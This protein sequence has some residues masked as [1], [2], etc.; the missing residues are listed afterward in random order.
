[1][2]NMCQTCQKQHLWTHTFIF[3]ENCFFIYFLSYS[4]KI[5]RSINSST[6]P[7]VPVLGLW[8]GMVH[9]KTKNT[10]SNEACQIIFVK[11]YTQMYKNNCITL[12][13]QYYNINN[14]S[15]QYI[16]LLQRYYDKLNLYH[17]IVSY[18]NIIIIWYMADDTASLENCLVLAKH[19]EIIHDFCF[20]LNIFLR[21]RYFYH[22]ESL[23][24][25][26]CLKLTNQ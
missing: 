23:Y 26:C 25:L 14:V 17:N 9:Y 13:W 11:V 5:L 22:W 2:D 19:L 16:W 18:D 12:S 15:I 20:K 8:P 24:K 3:L 7:F 4:W 10:N 1:M 6:L 21:F